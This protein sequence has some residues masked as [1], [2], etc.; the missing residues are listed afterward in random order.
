MKTSWTLLIASSLLLGGLGVDS[1]AQS[2]EG[3]VLGDFLASGSLFRPK[4]QTQ[5]DQPPRILRTDFDLTG[6]GSPEVFLSRPG[7]WMRNGFLWVVYEVT[8]EKSFSKLGSARYNDEL[9]RVTDPGS[10]RVLEPKGVGLWWLVEYNLLSG[11]LTEVERRPLSEANESEREIIQEER[12]AMRQ[13]WEER[14]I[15]S[16]RAEIYKGTITPWTSTETGEVLPDLVPISPGFRRAPSTPDQTKSGTGG[17]S[18]PEQPPLHRLRA[19]AGSIT[20]DGA[21]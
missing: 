9:V 2:E 18:R 19:P 12:A 4:G 3:G 13:F 8:G 17:T 20:R 10:L 11:K 15:P 21:S 16:A 7:S 5:K 14:D 6:D 1:Q